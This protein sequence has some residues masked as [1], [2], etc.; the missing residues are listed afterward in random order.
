M[1]EMVALE[2]TGTVNGVPLPVLP[3]VTVAMPDKSVVTLAGLKA[4]I[5]P[6]VGVVVS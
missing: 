4:F 1:L 2:T 3:D 5:E 6:A